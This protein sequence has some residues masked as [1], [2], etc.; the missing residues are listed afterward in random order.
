MI[1]PSSQQTRVL[2]WMSNN[3]PKNNNTIK[4][5][6]HTTSYTV[7]NVVGPKS[8]A[9]ISELTNSDITQKQFRYKKINIGFASD[10]QVMNYSHT[11]DK[12]GFCLYIPSEYALHVYDELINVGV[13]FGV[14]DVG[15]LTQRFMRV[16]RFIPFMGDE[17]T[18]DVTP[19]EAGQDSYV[20]FSK[21]FLGKDVLLEQKKNGIKKRLVLFMIDDIDIDSDIWPWGSEPIFRNSEYVGHVTTACYGFLSGKLI[22][23]G[24]VNAN[25]NVSKEYILE[26]GIK[27]HI[28]IANRFFE[29]TPY[30]Q[31]SDLPY[32]Q[33]LKDEQRASHFHKKTSKVFQ[34]KKALS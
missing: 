13:D 7:L 30:V 10:I 5:S 24:F 21:D 19:L 9:L 15:T 2:E 28:D 12:N 1:S 26:P 25:E 27:Y 6:D 34:L 18:S 17:L 3:L 29:A 14:K 31:R 4:L 8:L 32:L 16:E 20:D 23:L 33:E 11:G 22:C